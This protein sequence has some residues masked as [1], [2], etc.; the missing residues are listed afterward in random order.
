MKTTK[1]LGR[2]KKR[3]LGSTRGDSWGPMRIGIRRKNRSSIL[4]VRVTVHTDPD[5]MFLIKWCC[6]T[7]EEIKE[8]EVD[9]SDFLARQRLDD[10]ASIP[11]PKTEPD[12]DEV[13]HSLAHLTSVG[14]RSAQKPMKG[15]VQT[16]E[17]DEELENMIREK[18]AADANRGETKSAHKD[19]ILTGRDTGLG[20]PQIS[21]R[22]F[23]QAQQNNRRTGLQPDPHGLRAKVRRYRMLLLAPI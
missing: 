23:A 3:C 9:L 13:D 14:F 18:A 12:E 20:D 5:T 11:K 17:W 22:G 1:R 21:N 15:R 4:R 8:P 10:A 16:K 6:D 7:G 2:P 19:H